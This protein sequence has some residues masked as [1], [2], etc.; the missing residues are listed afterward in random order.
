VKR[1]YHILSLVFV[2]LFIFSISANT[3]SDNIKKIIKLQIGSKVAIVDG[4]EVK[5]DAP[6]QIINGKTMVP[7]R[8]VSEGLGAEVAWEQKTKTVTISM[9][10]IEYLNYEITNLNKKISERDDKVEELGLKVNNL[11][12]QKVKVTS[13]SCFKNLSDGKWI[14][15]ATTFTSTDEGLYV[16][17]GVEVLVDN[18]Y[19]LVINVNDPLGR[20]VYNFKFE[21]QEKKKG[22]KW[23]YRTGKLPIKNYLIGS[24][25]GTWKTKAMIDNKEVFLQKFII[26]KD[27]NYKVKKAELTK[28]ATCKNVVNGEP[29]EEIKTFST[30]D[31]KVIV[32]NKFKALINCGFRINYKFYDPNGNFYANALVDVATLN[33]DSETWAWGSMK[34][35]GFDPEKMPGNWKCKIYIEDEFI[36]ETGFKIE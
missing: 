36:K 25:P 6:A 27:E 30:N 23:N 18:T 35:K 12:N 22:E 20:T 32:F 3:R 29:E 15:P 24:I 14:D 4:K 26:T 7:V 17:F 33:K 5:M 11:E 19:T 16:G 2:F 13:S 8:F 31:E 10:S 9:D 34:I 21:K 1:T 28:I